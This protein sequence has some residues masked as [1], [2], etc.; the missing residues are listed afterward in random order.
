MPVAR[1]ESLIEVVH[2]GEG[3]DVSARTLVAAVRATLAEAPEG[4]VALFHDATGLESA[5]QEYAMVFAGLMRELP[6]SRV[7]QVAAVPKAWM[8]VLAKTASVLGGMEMHIFKTAD[9]ARGYL[10]QHGF[11]AAKVTAA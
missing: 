3:T 7:L 4:R 1:W 6:K 2:T 11:A 8:R 5:S 10:A 9:E